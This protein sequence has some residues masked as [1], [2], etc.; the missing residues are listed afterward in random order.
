TGKTFTTLPDYMAENHG[1]VHP[2]YTSTALH[3]L[4]YL[5]N[6]YGVFGAEVPKHAFFN[7]QKIYDRLKRTVDRHGYAH[8]AQGMDWM[9]LPADP[10]VLK[11]ATAAVLLGDTDGAAFERCALG[12]LEARLAGAGGRMI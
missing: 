8:P 7:R 10:G 2:G 6:L 12:T 4:G 5:A 1:M 11:H 3:F 9:Y